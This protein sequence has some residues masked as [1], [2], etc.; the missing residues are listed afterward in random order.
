MNCIGVVEGGEGLKEKENKERELLESNKNKRKRKER[1][2]K[3]YLRKHM[4][5]IGRYCR[6]SLFAK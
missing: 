6:K 3:E 1:R 2:D 5:K 4:A